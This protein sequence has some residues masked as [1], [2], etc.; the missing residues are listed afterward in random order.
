MIRLEVRMLRE[1]GVEIMHINPL[2]HLRVNSPAARLFTRCP[3]L[4]YWW[5]LLLLLNGVGFI[6]FLRNGKWNI[7]G[8]LLVLR[9]M[10]GRHCQRYMWC[11]Y[12]PNHLHMLGGMRV[13][14]SSSKLSHGSISFRTFSCVFEAISMYK[15]ACDLFQCTEV[16]WGKSC[17]NNVYM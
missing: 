14:F 12:D 3:L 4:P 10:N 6:Y 11:L 5:C 15:A 9:P 7:F 1:D 2:E 8:T 17:S 13:I 16:F